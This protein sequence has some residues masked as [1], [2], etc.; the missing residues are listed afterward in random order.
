M[1]GFI[2]RSIAPIQVP[3]QMGNDWYALREASSSAEAKWRSSLTARARLEG[4]KVV[5]LGDISGLDTA[6]LASCLYPAEVETDKEGKFVKFVAMDSQSLAD[7]NPQVVGS[8]PHRVVAPMVEWV[9]NTSGMNPRRTKADIMKE[10]R[11]LQRQLEEAE[12]TDPTKPLPTS[13]TTGSD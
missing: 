7:T 1:E 3:V 12:G 13:M 4:T 8:W 11:E 9:K 2:H 5:G 6:L 10:L